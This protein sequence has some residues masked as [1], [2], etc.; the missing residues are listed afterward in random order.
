M[1]EQVPDD[2]PN[3]IYAT[4][5]QKFQDSNWKQAITQLE[6]WDNRYPFRPFAAGTVRSYLRLLQK[7]PSAAGSGDDE[8]FH[9]SEPC[10]PNIDYVMY[11]RGLTK[12]A[13]DDMHCRASS[14][15]IVPTVT[16]NMRV[17]L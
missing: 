1:N 12:M 8:S 9:A 16:R 4:A 7:S 3:E 15:W 6:A 2:P 14:R 5:Q 17:M 11:M 13:L 10:P